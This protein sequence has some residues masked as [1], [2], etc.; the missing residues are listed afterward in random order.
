VAIVAM[1][2][3]PTDTKVTS[4]YPDSTPGPTSTP[5]PTLAIPWDCPP[6]GGFLVQI[7]S[8]LLCPG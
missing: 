7:A 2:T 6:V 3:P 8:P 1:S 4:V 5:N